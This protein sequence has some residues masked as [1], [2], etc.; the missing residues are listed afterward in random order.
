MSDAPKPTCRATRAMA[1]DPDIVLNT[2]ADPA[3]AQAW[4]P[5]PA[6]LVDHGAG[7]VDVAWTADGPVRRYEIGLRPEAHTLEWSPVG[8]DGWP[9]VL[10]VTDHGAGSSEAELQVETGG[11]HPEDDVRRVLERALEGLA[12]EVDQNFTVG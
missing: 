10:R 9:G 1:A 3:R 8:H 7:T 11:R 6:H 4:L 12:G 5:A 2:A